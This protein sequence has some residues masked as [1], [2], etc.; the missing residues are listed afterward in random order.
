MTKKRRTK[1]EDDT[2]CN[3]RGFKRALA[4]ELVG[5]GEVLKL[6]IPESAATMR[7]LWVGV[8]ASERTSG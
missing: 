1:V 4:C 2:I 6:R 3:A 7:L 5:S 8:E